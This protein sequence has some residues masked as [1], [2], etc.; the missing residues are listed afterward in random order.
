MRI[1]EE[2]SKR[3]PLL[4]L[5]PDRIHPKYIFDRKYNVLL[6]TDRAP[7]Y[8][9]RLYSD[10]SKNNAGS[11]A[12][13]YSAELDLSYKYIAGHTYIRISSGTYGHTTMRKNSPG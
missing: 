12:G 7:D 11:G 2:Y 9:I 13:I 10:G 4:H 8:D 1:L 3:I 5:E 6:N